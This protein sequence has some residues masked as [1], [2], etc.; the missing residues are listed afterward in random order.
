MKTFLTSLLV[1]T[2]AALSASINPSDLSVAVGSDGTTLII[3]S[4]VVVKMNSKVRIT[5]VNGLTLHT[6]E[7]KSGSAIN[8]RLQLSALPKGTYS[9]SFTDA[10]G[11]IV[12]PICL[13]ERGIVVDQTLAVQTYYPHVDLDDK[14]LTINYLNIPGKRVEISLSDDKGNEFVT[15]RLAASTTVQRAYSLENLPQGNYYVTVTSPGVRNHI[16]SLRLE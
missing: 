6:A 11:N 13:T 8:T 16:T 4:T 7:H 5:D 15:D 2:V 9:L 3:T 14:L 1:L 10:A 12:Q